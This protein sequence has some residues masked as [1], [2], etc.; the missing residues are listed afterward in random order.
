MQSSYSLGVPSGARR[1]NE[2]KQT[3]T[4]MAELTQGKAFMIG[5]NM[6][7]N[8]SSEVIANVVCP[9]VLEIIGGADMV[10][11]YNKQYNKALWRG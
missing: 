10:D 6:A 11:Q 7:S 5:A 2:A 8:A 3:F 1:G 4:E 9:Q